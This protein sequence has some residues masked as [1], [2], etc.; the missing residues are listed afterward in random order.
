MTTTHIEH[1][2]PVRSVS[3]GQIFH[4]LQLAVNTLLAWADR[5]RKRREL[6][7][8]LTSEERIFKDI[9]LQRH[10]VS[11]EAYKRFWQA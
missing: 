4:G 9:G 2:S 1:A 10:D 5:A 3:K 7:D 6:R 8:L 11:R